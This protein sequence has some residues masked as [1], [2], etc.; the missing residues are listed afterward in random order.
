MSDEAA[1]SV[2]GLRKSFGGRSVLGDV[3]FEVA[4]GETFALLGRNGAGKTTT[5]RILLGLL[6]ADAG[7]VRVAG[8][9]PAIADVELRRKVGYLAEDQ[10]MYALDVGGGVV[11]VFEA[12]LS[13]VGRSTGGEIARRLRSAAVRADLHA[14]EGAGGE[15]GAGGGDRTSAGGGDL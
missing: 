8:L 3:S 10:A 12:V 7:E 1:I 15:V 11:R 6:A 4:T 2:R 9:D 14:V 5:I 13:D